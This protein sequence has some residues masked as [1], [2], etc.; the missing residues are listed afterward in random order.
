MFNFSLFKKNKKIKE[1]NRN[2]DL[3]LEP[4]ICCTRCNSRL[5]NIT[6]VRI[7]HYTDYSSTQIEL[8]SFIH[9]RCSI[10]KQ[11]LIYKLEGVIDAIDFFELKNLKNTI[12]ILNKYID[13]TKIVLP[14][15]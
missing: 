4:Y 14:I 12:K 15:F 9:L 10:C 6:T 1:Q 7:L 8:I 2:F 11:D 3:T 5:L 13:I